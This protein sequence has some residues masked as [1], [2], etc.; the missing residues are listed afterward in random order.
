M[1]K[2]R[3]APESNYV[4]ADET[5]NGRKNVADDVDVSDVDGIKTETETDEI[6]A[7]N[8]N[9]EDDPGNVTP[10][11]DEPLPPMRNQADIER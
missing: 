5:K 7:S 9:S 1:G 11:E 10:T 3:V 4:V 8:Q 2:D 6:R